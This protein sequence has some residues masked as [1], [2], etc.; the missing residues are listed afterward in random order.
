MAVAMTSAEVLTR[1]RWTM[2]NAGDLSTPT[3][4]LQVT[5]TRTFTNGTGSGKVQVGIADQRQLTTGTDET[6][7]LKAILS[8][9]GSAALTKI[10]A[11]RI[12]LVTATAGYTLK[13]KAG[14]SNG[15]SAWFSDASDELVIQAGGAWQLESPVDG[16]VVD[17]THKT[18][19]IT[20]PAGGTATYNILILAE[21][22]VS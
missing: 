1:W 22:A 2:T 8:A 14:A 20:N 19:K 4:A 10:K 18:V 3:D 5:T 16:Y 13:V 11:V 21:G 9:F 15:L 7:D 17:A 6:L 12:E